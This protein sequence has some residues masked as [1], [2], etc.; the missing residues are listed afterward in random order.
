M[1]IN[2]DFTK[3][4]IISPFSSK[5]TIVAILLQKNNEGFE[6]S[7]AFFSKYLRHAS[8][9][10]NIMEKQAFAL[11]K[12]LKYFRVY[13]LH[14]HI[15]SYVPNVVVKDILTHNGPEGKRGKW[16]DVILEYDLYIKHT[17]LIK[18]QGLAKLMSESNFH[19]LYV[20]LV[21]SLDNQEEKATPK[22]D[23]AFL[24]SSWYAN[25]LY[26]LFNL[27]VL[28]GLTK[29]K[30]IFIKLKVVKFSIIDNVERC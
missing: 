10:Y 20:K 22:I 6:Q 24:N 1:L 29:T 12:A 26:V 23:K 2:L 21:E 19:A 16:I 8:L 27:N 25:L 3:D 11:V 14:S 30:A 15:I 13:I 28:P 5:H 17:K 4:F 9:K 7:I 18:G